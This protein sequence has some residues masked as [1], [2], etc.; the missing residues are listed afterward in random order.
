M[1]DRNSPQSNPMSPPERP[2]GDERWAVFLDVDG[3]LLELA[4]TP[5]AVYVPDSLV[6]LLE[7]LDRV[8]DGALAAFLDEHDIQGSGIA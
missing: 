8:L 5:D 3:T 1:R 6:R 2:S 4:D 7:A